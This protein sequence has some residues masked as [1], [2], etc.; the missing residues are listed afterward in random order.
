MTAPDICRWCKGTGRHV[1]GTSTLGSDGKWTTARRWGEASVCAYC[2]GSGASMLDR[3][4]SCGTE[5]ADWQ[6]RNCDRCAK[7]YDVDAE[8]WRCD[9]EFALNVNGQDHVPIPALRRMGHDP[10][11][12]VG[13]CHE[14]EEQE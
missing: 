7:G 9:L 3:P 10:N 11:D 12:P 8:T 1:P 14:F 6:S 4:F 13:R 5:F 2:R